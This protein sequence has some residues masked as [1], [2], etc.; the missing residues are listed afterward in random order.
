MKKADTL[1]TKVLPV[2]DMGCAI[3]AHHVENAVKSLP[4]IQC[5]AVH[6][7]TQSLNVSFYRDAVSL[8]KIQQA[9]RNAGYDLLLDEESSDGIPD[10]ESNQHDSSLKRKTIGAWILCFPLILLGTFFQSASYVNWTMMLLTIGVILLSGRSFYINGF[11]NLFRRQPNMDTLVAISTSI[12]FLFSLFNTL[13]PEFWIHRGITPHVYYEAAGIIIAFVLLGKLIEEKAR[14]ETTFAIHGL[15][16]LQ[17][18]MALRIKEGKEEK[19]PISLLQ[20]GDLIPIHP[21]ERIPVDGIVTEG[22][23]SV[24]ESMISGESSPTGKTKGDKVLA[25]T[26]NQKGTFILSV[27]Q[28]G[29]ETV[30]AHMVRM[31]REAQG[32]KAPVQRIVDKISSIFVPVLLGLALITF[33]C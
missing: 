18:R 16:G 1:V 23:S 17:P 13:Y 3:C 20:I 29:K 4:G 26:I 10:E 5:A 21:D 30:L 24:D 33:L 2:L 6:F 11:R 27:T 9:V 28:T 31:I 14:Q 25:G 32:S 12:A 19:V 7:A 22:S 8:P 15:L